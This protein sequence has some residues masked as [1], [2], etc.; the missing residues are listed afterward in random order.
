MAP[1]WG[2][3]N[4]NWITTPSIGAPSGTLIAWKTEIF[5]LVSPELRTYSLSVKLKGIQ[6][7]NSCWIA[8][9]YGP[10]SNLGKIEFWTTLNDLGDLV[11][12]PWCIDGS[13]GTVD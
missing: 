3:L 9:I 1:V 4:C 12:E 6:D 10:P 8:C 13:R 11:D 7:R 5:N 2:R